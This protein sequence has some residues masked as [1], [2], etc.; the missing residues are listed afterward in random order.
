MC[1]GMLR[2]MT[3]KLLSKSRKVWD[4]FGL[5]KGADG[6]PFDDGSAVC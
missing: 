4:Y 1:S 5:Q 3:E 6:N 2:V